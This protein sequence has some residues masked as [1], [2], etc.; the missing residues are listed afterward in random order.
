MAWGSTVGPQSPMQEEKAYLGIRITSHIRSE[1]K[2]ELK[3]VRKQ[4]PQTNPGGE[5]M[6][7]GKEPRQ[8]R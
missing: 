1:I 3:W 6:W 2:T 4:K 7:S 5:E 8:C